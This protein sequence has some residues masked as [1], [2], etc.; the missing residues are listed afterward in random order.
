MDLDVTAAKTKFTYVGEILP[1]NDRSNAILAQ[2]R[3]EEQRKREEAERVSL[4]WRESLDFRISSRGGGGFINANRNNNYR[5]SSS[6]SSARRR[7]RRRRGR[8][9][10]SS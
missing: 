1:N 10:R 6:R 8:R 3:D 9:R 4:A 5:S 2:R 7:E